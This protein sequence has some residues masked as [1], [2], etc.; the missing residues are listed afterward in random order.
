MAVLERFSDREP[1]Y[2]RKRHQPSREH[3]ALLEARRTA[4]REHVPTSGIG[5]IPPRGGSSGG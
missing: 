3:G 4:G 1:D 2:W 5:K